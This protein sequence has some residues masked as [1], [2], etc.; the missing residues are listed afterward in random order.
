[1]NG[2]DDAAQHTT[3]ATKINRHYAWAGESNSFFPASFRLIVTVSLAVTLHTC[4]CIQTLISEWRKLIFLWNCAKLNFIFLIS[5]YQ[6]SLSIFCMTKTH[7]THS[8]STFFWKSAYE[9]RKKCI[10]LTWHKVIDKS[11]YGHWCHRCQKLSSSCKNDVP[12]VS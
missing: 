2:V 8:Y 12:E 1:M 10:H 4:G 5:K 9:I 7:K 3:I 11:E 6:S